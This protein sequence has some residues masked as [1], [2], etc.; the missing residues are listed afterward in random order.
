M[1]SPVKALKL[2]NL[3]EISQQKKKKDLKL[4]NT[5]K[6]R[7][8]LPASLVSIVRANFAKGLNVADVYV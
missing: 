7:E 2:G 6:L 8:E 3:V 4:S 5:V 1:F